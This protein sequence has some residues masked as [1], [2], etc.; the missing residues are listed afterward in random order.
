MHFDLELAYGMPIV[1]EVMSYRLNRDMILPQERL[2]FSTPNAANTNVGKG[3][4][5]NP[6]CGQWLETV[7]PD[8][9][10]HPLRKGI[11][12]ELKNGATAQVSLM[13]V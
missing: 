12:Y 6:Q 7:N 4:S 9:N 5:I 11:C 10:G 2:D 8:S 13:D 3:G 1:A